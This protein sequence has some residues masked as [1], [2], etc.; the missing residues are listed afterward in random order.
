MTESA[1]CYGSYTS[2]LQEGSEKAISDL[3]S[4]KVRTDRQ[5]HALAFVESLDRFFECDAMW[6]YSGFRRTT[7]A[8]VDHSKLDGL[9]DTVMS[10]DT[11]SWEL[12]TL[13]A[14][15]VDRRSILNRYSLCESEI[16]RHVRTITAAILDSQAVL[17][18]LAINLDPNQAEN[19]FSSVSVIDMYR[20]RSEYVSNHIGVL[21]KISEDLFAEFLQV[22]TLL[23][24]VS[25]STVADESSPRK[26]SNMATSLGSDK[27]FEIAKLLE[28]QLDFT[29]ARIDK[30]EKIRGLYSAVD[31]HE[32]LRFPLE[33]WIKGPL[34]SIELEAV[35]YGI[36]IEK[37]Q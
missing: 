30:L 7:K 19:T 17:S 31:V 23:L 37:Y 20:V 32:Q 9:L 15:I 4:L 11:S 6:H 26:A 13:V 22:S 28:I 1:S 2:C 25:P 36:V 24:T 8:P 33:Q 3:E 29:D 12:Y 21:H 16:P 10:S 27:N 34:T 18:E 5:H 14:S 35:E